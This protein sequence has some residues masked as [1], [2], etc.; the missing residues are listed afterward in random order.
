MA[1]FQPSNVIPSSFAGI[2]GQTVDAND[3]MS[4]SWQ[5]N[6]NSPMTAFKLQIYNNKTNENVLDSTIITL[7]NPFYGVDNKGNPKQFMYSP[8]NS[9]WS[10]WGVENGNEYKMVITQF[11]GANNANSVTQYSGSVFL[12]RETPTVS[13]TFNPALANGKGTVAKQSFGATVIPQG[14]TLNSV[15]WQFGS[16]DSDIS[17]LTNPID[18]SLVT[19]IDDTGAIN[20]AVLEYEYAGLF[21]GKNYAINCIIETQEGIEQSSGWQAF[22]VS[23][24][25]AEISESN[26]ISTECLADDS[27]LLSWAEAINIKGTMSPTGATPT[28]E[29]GLLELGSSQSVTWNKVNNNAMNFPSPWTM[30]WKAKLASVLNSSYTVVATASTTNTTKQ[31]SQT[32][33]SRSL[34]NVGDTL[35]TASVSGDIRETKMAY[36]LSEYW[37]ITKEKAPYIYRGEKDN[38]QKF[39][40]PITPNGS[41]TWQDIYATSSFIVFATNAR[42]YWYQIPEREWKYVDLGVL[43]GTRNYDYVVRLCSDGSKLMAY[44]NNNSEYIAYLLDP[45]GGI[46]ADKWQYAKIQT[47]T[48]SYGVG[49]FIEIDGIFALVSG[50]KLVVFSFDLSNA[51][52]QRDIIKFA[53]D[54]VSYSQSVYAGRDNNARKIAILYQ[55]NDYATQLFVY[56]LSYDS[57]TNTITNS[58]GYYLETDSGKGGN[59]ATHS[60]SIAYGN[61]ILV[62]V[63]GGD[64]SYVNYKVDGS[65]WEKAF[66]TKHSYDTNVGE[67]NFLQGSFL[68]PLSNNILQELLPT[69]IYQVSYSLVGYYLSYSIN[70]SADTFIFDMNISVEASL[71]PTAVVNIKTKT[72][73]LNASIVFSMLSEYSSGQKTFSFSWGTLVAVKEVQHS[74]SNTSTTVKRSGNSITISVSLPTANKYAQ[75]TNVTV[76]LCQLYNVLL[77]SGTIIETDGYKVNAVINSASDGLY[78][79][80]IKVIDKDTSAVIAST[81]AIN[82]PSYNVSY[83]LYGVFALKNNSANFYLVDESGRIYSESYSTVGEVLNAISSVKLM[84]KQSCDWLYIGSGDIDI[85]KSFT[86]KWEDSTLFLADFLTQQDALQAGTSS[87]GGSLLNAM[88]RQAE[89]KSTLDTVL[90]IP[91]KY[92]KIR[93]YGIRSG[94]EYSWEMFYLDGN[95]TYSK[96]I[97]SGTVCRQFR[98]YTLL[99]AWQDDDNANVYHVIKVWRFG[100]NLSVGGI[101]NNNTPNWLTNFTPYRLRQPT[102][103]LGQSG[104]LQALLSNFNQSENFYNDTIKMADDLKNASASVNTFFLKDMKGNL[105]MVGI[106]APITQTM[107]IKSKVQEIT[108]SVAWEEVG[109]ANN[110]SLIQLP[111]DEG[112]GKDGVM[113][114]SFIANSSNGVLSVKY[115]QDY[116]GTTFEMNNNYLKAVT[117]KQLEGQVDLSIEDGAVKAKR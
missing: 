62:V 106:S 116:Y 68:C 63:A 75:T 48:S 36:G 66:I 104:T 61:N 18:E 19:I 112:W 67:L 110:V 29:N 95:S 81:T 35:F 72:S 84:G 2:G 85:N 4:V 39:K 82:L 28:V 92:N 77:V 24:E 15:R 34:D 14:T 32:L 60:C 99:E 5:V 94:Q 1:I 17:D 8:A 80:A 55:Q 64:C 117:P 6:G 58:I 21:T 7:D 11:W 54:G 86:P 70:P 88:Y 23:Y 31:I 76:E 87:E 25:E 44:C 52:V 10:A 3:N 59:I 51:L 13:I 57:S 101:S 103:R 33:S 22:T 113:D 41:E 107:N 49:D 114:V 45:F 53:N 79:Y 12:A 30:G 90:E 40:I 27:V 73:K 111:D 91:T 108:I 56:E 26:I 69:Y 98:Q 89:G 65:L 42:I 93:D 100:N 20:T 78:N 50:S 37:A 43:L 71:N 96:P 102:A 47:L 83:D 109:D 46:T 9:K 38:L 115:P 16:V 97:K 105:Y 74:P